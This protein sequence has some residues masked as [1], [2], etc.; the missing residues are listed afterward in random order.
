MTKP[1]LILFSIFILISVKTNLDQNLYSNSNIK[2]HS[3]VNKPLQSTMDISEIIVEI[4]TLLPQLANFINQF[5]TTVNQSGINVMTDSIGNLSISVPENMADNVIKNVSN[6]IY[7]IDRL[8]TTRGEEINVLL[9]KGIHLENNLKAE[10]SNYV[11]QL[12]SKTE[13]FKKLTSSYN[14]YLR[15]NANVQLE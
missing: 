12:T 7:I 5:N 11:S 13:E 4:N 6:K 14:H 3:F 2:P 8:I 1:S 15:I 9:Q 10:N